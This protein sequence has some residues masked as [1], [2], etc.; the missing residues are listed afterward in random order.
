MK[1]ENKVKMIQK[2]IEANQAIT[3]AYIHAHYE[4]DQSLFLDLRFKLEEWL[5]KEMKP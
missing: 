2:A 1:E 4:V 3:D 5:V